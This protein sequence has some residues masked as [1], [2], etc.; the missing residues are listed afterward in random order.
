MKK[1]FVISL[2]R[3]GT[4]SLALMAGMCGL[5][6]RHVGID[7]KSVAAENDFLTD[8]PYFSPKVI[9]EMK[10]Y[11][12]DCRFIYCVRDYSSQFKS[13][14]AAHL[15]NEFNTVHIDLNK[16]VSVYQQFDR[17]HYTDSIGLNPITGDNCAAVFDDHRS[18]VV[19]AVG[20]S[21]LLFYMFSY[22]WQPFCD[23]IECEV[24]NQ[25]IPHIN[26]LGQIDSVNKM[27]KECK[28][29]S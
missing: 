20:D 13:W 19:K 6:A 7:Y 21:P 22:G 11:Y 5:N 10:E 17:K 16:R 8:T 28:Q 4:S 12:D 25:P 3:S 24:P 29:H 18:K 23:F 1:F 26:K 15:V 27:I 9:C 14:E 2:P